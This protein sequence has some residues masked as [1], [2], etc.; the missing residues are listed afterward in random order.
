MN[1]RLIINPP[2]GEQ[3]GFPRAVPIEGTI[4]YGS[5][6]DYGV[7]KD[8]NLV[9]WL[10]SVGYPEDLYDNCGGEFLCS[11]WTVPAEEVTGQ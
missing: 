5:K 1:R 2:S 3:Y 10:F 9:E 8:F 4:Y 7:Q 11:Y 6:Y